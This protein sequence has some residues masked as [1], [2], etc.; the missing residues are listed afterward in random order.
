MDSILLLWGVTSLLSQA[1]LHMVL[2]NSNLAWVRSL[3]GW[4]LLLWEIRC[5]IQ[6]HR[7]KDV[8]R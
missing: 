5:S 6:L 7:C 2:L 4:A 3:K 8:H 1:T